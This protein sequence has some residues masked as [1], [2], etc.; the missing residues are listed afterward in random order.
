M[1]KCFEED[2]KRMVKPR[3]KEEHLA[4]CKEFLKSNYR[5]FKETYKYYAAIGRTENLFAI[6]KLTLTDFI[7]HKIFLYD[8]D[9]LTDMDLTFSTVKG[10]PKVAKFQPRTAL[11]RFEF[12]ELLFRLAL[13]RYLECT[14]FLQW[15]FQKRNHSRNPK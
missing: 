10:R 2:W 7:A 8:G 15:L 6:N 12:V 5:I 14:P 13:K 4:K 11:V 1:A 3:M 9:K